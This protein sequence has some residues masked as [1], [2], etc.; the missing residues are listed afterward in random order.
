MRALQI[1]HLFVGSPLIVWCI[2]LFPSF[3]CQPFMEKRCCF[4][5]Y[6]IIQSIRLMKNRMKMERKRNLFKCVSYTTV[7]CWIA[8]YAKRK[9]TKVHGKMCVF[10]FLLM[11]WKPKKSSNYAIFTLFFFL[12]FSN[13]QQGK[14]RNNAFHLISFCVR[15]SIQKLGYIFLFACQQ[16]S[17]CT[18]RFISSQCNPEVVHLDVYFCSSVK[19]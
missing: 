8:K 3:L 14:K 6:N 9:R 7:V 11:I 16:H 12:Y 4:S 15:S 18:F 2:Q 5:L 13:K 19:S 10:L 1:S 17:A